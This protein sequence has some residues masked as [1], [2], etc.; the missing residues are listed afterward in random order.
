MPR[1]PTLSVELLRTLVALVRNNG[2]AAATARELKINQPSMSKRLRAFQHPGG[3]LAR[4]WVERDGHTWRLTEE[5]RSAYP[6]VQEIIRR[7]RQLVG[8]PAAV[9]TGPSVAF[10]C[11]QTSVLGH[12]RAALRL[13]RTEHPGIRVQIRTLRSR[14]RLEELAAVGLDLAE[15]TTDGPPPTRMKG[16]PLIT[17]PLTRE[18]LYLAAGEGTVWG[19]MLGKLPAEVPLKPK[20]VARLGAPLLLPETSA[21]PRRVFD[22]AMSGMLDE[23]A[24][25]LESGGWGALLAFAEDGHGVAMVSGAALTGRSGFV[26]RRLDPAAFPPV[27]TI[28]VARRKTGTRDEPDLSPEGEAFRRTLI[29]VVAEN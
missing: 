9:L 24:V 28:L 12:V 10:G 20:S 25:D 23:L 19:A 14:Q 4:P 5:G 26:S 29:A 7:Y 8:E 2:D 13:F 6:A 27:R 3:L 21:A 16:K 22:H 11:G 15:I 17:W 18:G 1:P